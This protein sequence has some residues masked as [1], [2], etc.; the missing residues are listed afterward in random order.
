M[1][2]RPSHRRA[3]PTSFAPRR[4]AIHVQAW[5]QH[6]DLGWSYIE[7]LAQNGLQPR[8]GNGQVMQAVSGGERAFGIVI[9]YLPIREAQ[10]GAPVRFIFPE[11][12]VSAITEPAAIL[13]TARNV[14]AAVAFVNFLLSR[15]GQ[16]LASRQGFLP[17]DPAV[18]PPAGFPDPRTIRIMPLDAARAAAEGEANLRRFAQLVGG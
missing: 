13:S 10:R 11:E 5:A 12:G 14:P 17:A 8:G 15:E 7:R 6:P 4:A 16:E 18:A 2:A 1:S 3:G 9:D